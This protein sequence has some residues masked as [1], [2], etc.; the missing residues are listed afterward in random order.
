MSAREVTPRSV[1][2]RHLAGTRPFDQAGRI[3]DAWAAEGYRVVSQ[4]DTG[5]LLTADERRAVQLA[6]ELWNLLCNIVED[7]PTREADLAELVPH[8]HAI[9]QAVMSQAAGRAYPELY[10]RLGGVLDVHRDALSAAAE[11]L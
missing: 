11:A 8:V 9:Q 1:L 4:D 10:R 3:L 7:G 2:S 6:G 5:E